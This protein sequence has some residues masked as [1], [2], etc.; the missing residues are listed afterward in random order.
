MV[1][2]HVIFYNHEAEDLGSLECDVQQNKA[3]Q[4]PSEWNLSW[5]FRIMLSRIS[6]LNVLHRHVEVRLG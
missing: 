2:Q 3:R 5:G 1:S 4:I 6:N